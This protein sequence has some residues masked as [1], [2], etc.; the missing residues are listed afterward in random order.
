MIGLAILLY[1]S[2]AFLLGLLFLYFAVI[3]FKDR[4]LNKALKAVL[5]GVPF[6]FV[7]WPFIVGRLLFEIKCSTI[8]GLY[9]TPSIDASKDGYY[10]NGVPKGLVHFYEHQAV[11]DLLT[12]R[13][14]FFEVTFDGGSPPNFQHY[15][16]FI[17]DETSPDCDADPYLYDALRGLRPPSGK[18]FAR[19]WANEFKSSYVVD[20][21]SN[22]DGT[23]FYD[24]VSVK[25]RGFFGKRLASYR[26]VSLPNGR[27]TNHG[28]S[29]VRC[30]DR[31]GYFSPREAITAMIFRDNNGKVITSND[32]GSFEARRNREPNFFGSRSYMELPPREILIEQIRSTDIR[33]SRVHDVNKNA[34]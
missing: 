33:N 26:T 10:L 8:A 4:S 31:Y 2:V 14:A 9:L 29:T 16:Y 11:Q 12:G 32:L 30:S 7:T 15:R 20:G 18:C 24:Y 21:Y 5:T 22:Y 28:I 3:Y 25:E 23:D 1:L 6:V 34:Q 27:I 19:V 17:D 13:I